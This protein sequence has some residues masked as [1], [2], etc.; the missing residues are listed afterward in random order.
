M[1][2]LSL[3]ADNYSI[4]FILSLYLE[5]SLQTNSVVTLDG[6]L[7]ILGGQNY[8]FC[9]DSL[10]SVDGGSGKTYFVHLKEENQFHMGF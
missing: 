9:Q 5:T 7:T 6:H 8:R 10:V 3:E 1:D 4:L 2:D